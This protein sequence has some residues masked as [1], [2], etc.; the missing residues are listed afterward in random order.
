M[1]WE[2]AEMS[3]YVAIAYLLVRVIREPAVLDGSARRRGSI[4]RWLN[5]NAAGSGGQATTA[6]LGHAPHPGSLSSPTLPVEAEGQFGQARRWVID[7]I[8]LRV[9][10]TR[11]TWAS[12]GASASSMAWAMSGCTGMI[13]PSPAPLAPSGFSGVGDSRWRIS[14]DR[15]ASPAVASV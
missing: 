6:D 3:L 12:K 9:M 1:M 13:P 2:S 11:V 7:Q 10:G 8:S 15:G 5:G 14:N 4:R